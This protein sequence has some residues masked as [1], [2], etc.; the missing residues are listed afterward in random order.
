MDPARAEQCRQCAACGARGDQGHLLSV[1][2]PRLA[3]GDEVTVEVPLP[4]PWRGI[5]LV[6][7]LPL[8][9]GITGLLVGS[10]WTGFQRA[11]GLEAEP[12][13]MLLGAAMGVGAFLVALLEDRRFRRAYPPRVVEVRRAAGKPAVMG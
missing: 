2:D 12:A 7:A 1:A 13:G 6:L 4:G 3:V 9:A 8:A 11:V 5:G 10:A